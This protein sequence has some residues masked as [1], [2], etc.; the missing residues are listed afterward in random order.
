M[1]LTTN[2]AFDTH[3]LDQRL[4]AHQA[5]TCLVSAQPPS[6]QDAK[7]I[8]EPAS[9]ISLSRLL[10]LVSANIKHLSA[11][12]GQLVDLRHGPESDE[13]G[14]LRATTHADSLAS[15]L[16]VDTAIVAG[17]EGR[18]IPYACVSTDSE[19]GLRI[20]WV[21]SGKNVHLVVPFS[22]AKDPYI[23]HGRGRR[24]AIEAATPEILA[25]WLREID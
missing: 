2:I 18:E 7:A 24:Y 3:E 17:Q 14:V 11:I 20:E 22:A 16:I 8:S 23:Y 12:I 19:G 21:R 6:M 10:G 1:I 25:Q 4:A 9:P 13:Y 5:Y 15:N